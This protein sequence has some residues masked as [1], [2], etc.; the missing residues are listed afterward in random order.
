LE[1]IKKLKRLK[2]NSFIILIRKKEMY[3]KSKKNKTKTKNNRGAGKK[4]LLCK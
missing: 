4:K 2:E 1:E 3:S